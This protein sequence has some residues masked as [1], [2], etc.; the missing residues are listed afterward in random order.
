M[1]VRGTPN[2]NRGTRGT[3]NPMSLSPP[4][5][6]AS[7]IHLTR[8]SGMA[9]PRSACVVRRASCECECVMP[10][11]QCGVLRAVCQSSV[12][13]RWRTGVW[14]RPTVSEATASAP[15][16][17]KR[18][19]PRAVPFTAHRASPSAQDDRPGAV[20]CRLVEPEAE[21]KPRSANGRRGG[22]DTAA[23]TRTRTRASEAT[24]RTAHPG[25]RRTRNP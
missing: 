3:R 7:L 9:V 8:R 4:T 23:S 18:G 25:T 1:I 19:R 22:P 21:S 6:A 5:A 13:V 10:S 24:R 12:G 11:G 20:V 14:I 15:N 16:R 17:R 2:Q